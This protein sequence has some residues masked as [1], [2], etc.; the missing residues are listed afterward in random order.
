MDK[1]YEGIGFTILRER[2]PFITIPKCILKQND[3]TFDMA[4]YFRS[5]QKIEKYFKVKFNNIKYK[6]ITDENVE[7]VEMLVAK[8]DKKHYL[9]PFGYLSGVL[10]KDFD[11]GFLSFNDEEMS[12]C[13]QMNKEITVNIHGHEFSLGY[14]M[15]QVVEPMIE[16]MEDIS[17][18]KTDKLVLKSK[19]NIQ[20]LFFYDEYLG[21]NKS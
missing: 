16:N 1:I 18:R 13:I 2:K 21:D 4:E 8:I 3:F 19:L 14:I 20:R 11:T 10:A 15:S 7:N 6:D 5:L 12:C 9:K 17:N